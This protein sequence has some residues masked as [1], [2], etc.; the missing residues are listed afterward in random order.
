MIDRRARRGAAKIRILL[1]DDQV[2]FRDGLRRLLEASGQIE[3]VA[4]ARD[5]RQALDMVRD[6]KPQVAVVET[7]MPLLNGLEVTRL[8]SRD[9][10]D[11]KVILLSGSSGVDFAPQALKAGAAGLLLKTADVI[12]LQLAI[13]KVARGETYFGSSIS[14]SILASYVQMMEDAEN[15]HGLTD[16][17]RE[18]LQLIAEGFGNQEIANACYISVKTVEAHKTNMMKKLSLASRNELLMYAV[19]QGMAEPAGE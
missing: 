14:G 2:M 19:R 5:G 11:V 6:V 16:R 3:V 10:P 1:A 18:I 9:Y 15:T 7:A 4:T 17:E 13:K 8:I 12:E